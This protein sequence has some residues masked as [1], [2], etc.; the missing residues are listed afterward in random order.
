GARRLL[1]LNNPEQLMVGDLGDASLGDKTLYRVT[2]GG[3]NR[4]FFEHVNRTGRTLGFGV[5][6]YNPGPAMARVT[7]VASGFVTGILGGAPFVE[8]LSGHNGAAAVELAA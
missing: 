5:Q 3:A 7:V 6:V 2:V 4:S 1:F 8:V